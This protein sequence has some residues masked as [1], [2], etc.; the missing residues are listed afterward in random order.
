M[1]GMQ[2]VGQD[3]KGYGESRKFA[4]WSDYVQTIGRG[5]LEALVYAHSH[6]TI[7]RDIKPTNVLVELKSKLVYGRG[8]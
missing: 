1:I 5:I 8:I 4:D 3:L 7:H 2:L 6:S